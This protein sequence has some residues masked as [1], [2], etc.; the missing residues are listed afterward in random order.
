MGIGILNI[1]IVR[2]KT[3]KLHKMAS[4]NKWFRLT[5]AILAQQLRLEKIFK[6]AVA[7]RPAAQG[8]W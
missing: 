3:N 4:A 8:A 7:H 1:Y 2:T 5:G 6:T